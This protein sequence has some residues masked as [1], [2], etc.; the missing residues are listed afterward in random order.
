MRK[1]L[2]VACNYIYDP[3]VGDPHAG[4]P[5]GTAFES[6]PDDWACPE[7]GATK[8]DFELYEE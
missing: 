4:I 1:Y 8:A 2:C 5:P 6:L 3:A 7:C